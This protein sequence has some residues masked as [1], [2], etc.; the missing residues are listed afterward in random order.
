MLKLM[1]ANISQ[2]KVDDCI[3]LYN[4]CMF[5]IE[6]SISLVDCHGNSTVVYSP[7]YW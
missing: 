3:Q 1:V 2:P 7:L 4:H 6:L 5:D